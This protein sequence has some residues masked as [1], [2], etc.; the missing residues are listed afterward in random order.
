MPCTEPNILRHSPH[1]FNPARPPELVNI[2]TQPK[3]EYWMPSRFNARTSGPDGS[4]VVWNTLTG[5]LT[6]VPAQKRELLESFL[7]QRGRTGPLGPFGEY[8]KKRGY[9]VSRDTDEFSKFQMAFGKQHYRPDILEL[10]LMSSGDCNFRCRYCY[11]DFNNGTMKP[12][13]RSGI[14]AYVRKRSKEIRHLSI[15][16]FGG[17]PLYGFEAIEDLGPFFTEMVEQ[18][19]WSFSAT[20]TTNGY[21]LEP[22]IA[23]KLLSWRMNRFQITIDGPREHHDRNRPGRDG[24]GTFSTILNNLIAIQKRPDDFFIR[25]RVNYDSDNGPHIEE[26][27][28]IFAPHFAGDTRFGLSFHPIGKWGGE[29]DEALEPCGRA[30]STDFRADFQQGAANRGL[31]IVNLSETAGLGGQ[32]CYAARPY[33]LLIGPDGKIMKC[34]VV[35]DK[36]DYNIVGQVDE[37]GELNINDERL[38]KWVAPAFETDTNCQSCHMLGTCQGMSCPLARFGSGESPCDATSK[39]ALH[40]ELMGAVIARSAQ[41]RSVKIGRKPVNA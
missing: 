9:V 21:L 24:S 10:I 15:S 34:T 20:M 3:Q 12:A 2:Q 37:D 13:V 19:G 32:V 11:E 17:E 14:K 4:V 27:L 30:E 16:W 26:L 39:H 5:S 7:S 22:E 31:N 28:D 25:L 41:A 1:D 33:N 36:E 35:L 40:D 29:N 18:N 38:A 6:V 8:L 23:A